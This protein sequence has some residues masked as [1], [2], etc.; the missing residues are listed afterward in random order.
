MGRPKKELKRI[1][2]RKVKKAKNKIKLYLKKEL[3]L[4]KLPKKAKDI[5]RKRKK[6]ERRAV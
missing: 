6:R 3:T 4:E 5:L 2:A 1:H